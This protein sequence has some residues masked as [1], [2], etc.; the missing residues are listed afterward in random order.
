MKDF[1]FRS[2]AA[3]AVLTVIFVQSVHLALAVLAFD[4]LWGFID[5]LIHNPAG[6]FDAALTVICAFGPLTIAL[7]VARSGGARLVC[8]YRL[9]LLVAARPSIMP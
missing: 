1:I 2:S 9:H 8:G 7:L 6:R 5:L 3:L 4:N